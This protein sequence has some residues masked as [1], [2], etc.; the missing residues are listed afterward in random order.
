VG[1]HRRGGRAGRQD[2]H[3]HRA[4]RSIAIK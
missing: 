2:D 3:R 1:R 4:Y